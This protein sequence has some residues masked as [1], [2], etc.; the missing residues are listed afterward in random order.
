[1]RLSR[2]YPRLPVVEFGR[3]LLRSQDLDPVYVALQKL[4]LEHAQ[5]ARWLLAYWLF[6]HC[7]F[8]SFAAERGGKAYWALLLQAAENAAPSP[9]KERWPR[10][11]ERRHFRGEVA[12]RAVQKLQ[13]RYGRNPQG[14]L[15]GVMDGPP[16]LLDVMARV[17]KHYL[18]GSWISFKVAD[19]LDA[20]WGYSVDQADLTGFLYDTPRRSILEKWSAGVL[21]LKAQSG[22]EALVEA[23]HWLQEQLDDVAV[24]HKPQLPAPDWFALETVWCKHKSHL[25][26]HYPLYKDSIEIAAGCRGWSP[27]SE[28]ARRFADALPSLPKEG[29]LCSMSR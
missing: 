16:T 14:F 18:F 29:L 11:S 17:Q 23:F 15:D 4:E 3:Q 19:M 8:A 7:G 9:L 1:M 10:G 21:P 27:V 2:N 5:L 22:E 6:Y 25:G 12:I 26:G 13:E 28:L 20:V 24:P